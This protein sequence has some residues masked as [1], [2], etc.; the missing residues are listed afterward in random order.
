[1]QISGTTKLLGIIGDPVEHS[2]SPAMHNAAI[3]DLQLDYVYLPFPVQPDRL[4]DALHGFAA[5]GLVGFNATIPHKQ[6]IMPLLDEI[7]PAAQAIGAVNTVWRSDR[8][9][10]GT[11]TDITGFIA[12]LKPWTDW[13]DRPVILLGNGGAA[14]AVVAGANQ[15]GCTTVQVVGRNAEKVTEFVNSWQ[16]SPLTVQISG[17]T[18]AELTDLL[19]H[20]GLIVNST[21]IGM[22]PHTAASPLSD[23]LAALI[24]PQAIAYDLIYT[25]SPTQFLQQAHQQ[26]ATIIDGLEMLVQQG[27]AAFEIWTGQQPPIATMRKVLRDRLGLN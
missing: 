5:I 3:A 1:M 21:P 19:P 24:K 20:A 2:L 9:W 4:A 17:H 10:S 11:N 15:L 6:A 25:P 8:G 14:R 22:Y 18:W 12:P 16:D 23:E 27:A 7:T 13:R 26:G